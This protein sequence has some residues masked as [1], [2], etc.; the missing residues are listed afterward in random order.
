MAGIDRTIHSLAAIPEDVSM[1]EAEAE[2]IYQRAF[3]G[4]EKTLGPDHKS[5]AC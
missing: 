5:S 3:D 2:E 4:S 1:K